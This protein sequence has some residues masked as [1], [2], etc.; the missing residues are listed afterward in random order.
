M[1]FYTLKNLQ[2]QLLNIL[3][4]KVPNYAKEVQLLLMNQF[5]VD[6]I[7]IMLHQDTIM[8]SCE[9]ILNKAHKRAMQE[10]LE[11]ITKNV[12]FYS[13]TFFIDYGALIPRPETELLIDEVLRNIKDK[14]KPITIVEIGVGSGV[15]SIMLA[16]KLKNANIIAVDISKDALKIAKKN[17]DMFDLNEQIELRFSSSLENVEEDIDYLVSN[18]PYI[19]LHAD[20]E[21]NLDFEPHEALFGGEVGCEFIFSLLNE[22]LN[23]RIK[24]FSCEIGYDQKDMINNYL[25]RFNDVNIEFYKDLSNLD[26]G[27][28]IKSQL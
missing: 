1:S 20:I 18:P 24:I 6:E 8:H 27:F 4:D 26:R 19:S 2:Q 22:Y 9:E 14:N 23:K 5:H 17:I 28:T 25:K 13:H 11:Y 7:W 12:S 15:V 16:K 10:P 21:K 3:K